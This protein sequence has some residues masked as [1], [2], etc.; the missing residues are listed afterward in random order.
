ML[1]ADNLAH[2]S[3][4][5]LIS[6][7]AERRGIKPYRLTPNKVPVNKPFIYSTGNT[8]TALHEVISIGDVSLVEKLLKAGADITLKNMY[9]KNCLEWAEHYENKDM[10][11]LLRKYK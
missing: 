1:F 7:A 4:I 11:D 9:D 10:V 2:P 8:N 3:S 6:A 5:S